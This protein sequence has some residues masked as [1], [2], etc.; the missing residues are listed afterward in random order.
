MPTILTKHDLT[1]CPR[2]G[3]DNKTV[4]KNP[5]HNPNILCRDGWHNV[6]KPQALGSSPLD[7]PLDEAT[8]ELPIVTAMNRKLAVP[9]V[10]DRLQAVYNICSETG[11]KHILDIAGQLGVELKTGES[12]LWQK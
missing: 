9:S 12:S 4:H 5:Y 3:S 7:Y 2:C 1:K 8:D 6:G 10:R 11:R